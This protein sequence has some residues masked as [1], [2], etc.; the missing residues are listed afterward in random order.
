MSTLH[1]WRERPRQLAVVLAFVAG[2]MLLDGV[3]QVVM[4]L[5]WRSWL[6]ETL[7]VEPSAT[8]P[9]ASD[10]QPAST[11]PTTKQAKP[12]AKQKKP[13]TPHKVHAAITNRNIFTQPKPKGHGL[14]LTGVMGN[15]AMFASRSGQTVGIAEGKSGQGVKVLSIN[16]YEVKIEYQGTSETMKLKFGGG[17][18]GPSPRGAR[19]GPSRRPPGAGQTGAGPVGPR[20]SRGAAPSPGPVGADARP[21][22]M[23]RSAPTSQP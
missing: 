11:Q 3:Y 21:S 14:T 4:H 19:P 15:I 18:G 20:P 16:G 7:A 13:A 1:V 23:R 22:R 2:V 10:S 5:R 17:P 8:Q 6:P 12:A 9:S